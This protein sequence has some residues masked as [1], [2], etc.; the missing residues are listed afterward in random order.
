MDH[1]LLIDYA[2]Q[3]MVEYCELWLMD[4]WLLIKYRATPEKFVGILRLMDRWL[5][6]IESTNIKFGYNIRLLTNNRLGIQTR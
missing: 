3:K 1:R 6:I 5:L 4:C 2:H